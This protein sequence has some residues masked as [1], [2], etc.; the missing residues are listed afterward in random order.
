MLLPCKSNAKQKDT[1]KCENVMGVG[2]YPLRLPFLI[3]RIFFDFYFESRFIILSLN[4]T[5]LDDGV[6]TVFLAPP[7]YIYILI[8]AH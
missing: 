1:K 3:P 6:H 2:C 4:S 7:R 5:I 8:F